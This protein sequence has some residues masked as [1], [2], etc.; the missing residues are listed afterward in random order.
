ML[1]PMRR[2]VLP[3]LAGLTALVVLSAGCGAAPPKIGPTGIDELTIPTPSPD[4]RDF[5]DTVDNS[6]LPL[7]PGTQWVYRVPGSSAGVVTRVLDRRREIAGVST[8]AVVTRATG[9]GDLD[10]GLTA[11][12][13]TAW[14]AQD[15]SGNVWLFGQRSA[16]PSPRSES[17]P[18]EWRAGEDGAEA[19]LAMAAHPRLGDGYWVVHAPGTSLVKATVLSVSESLTQL[20]DRA[21]DLVLIETIAEP[22]DVVADQWYAP[23]VGPVRRV[24]STGQELTL[25]STRQPATG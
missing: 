18:V 22:G 20:G 21:H 14:Y 16:A 12:L 2:R 11:V 15:R 9:A 3:I 23:D 1:G 13:G 25:V 19:G 5:V 17:P 6:Y 8:T 4:P 10:D 7:T 24:A